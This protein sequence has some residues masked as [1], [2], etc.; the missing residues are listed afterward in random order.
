LANPLDK[1]LEFYTRLYLQEDI[2]VKVD[3]AAMMNSLE[4]RAVFLDNDL[5]DFCR[6]LPS[7]FKLRNGVSKYIM[8]RAMQDRL[9]Q[10]IIDRSKKGFGIPL[11]SWLKEIPKMPPTRQLPGFCPVQIERLWQEHRQGTADHRLILWA[12]LA[13]QYGLVEQTRVKECVS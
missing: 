10:Q 11:A 7:H 4:T 12:W 6:R 5:V 8:K 13:L 3:R 1:A 2:L 9:P